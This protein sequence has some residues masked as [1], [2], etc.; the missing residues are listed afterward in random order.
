MKMDVM[1]D[2]AQCVVEGE[3][4]SMESLINK[5]LEEGKSASE[6]INSGLVAGMDVVSAL[7]KDGELFVPEVL[8]SA[9][10]MGAG[11]DLLK[12]LLKDAD[13]NSSGKVLMLTVEGDL[14]DIGKNLCSVMLESAG[15]EVI[16]IG[17]DITPQTVADAVKEHKPDLVGM[18]A[19]LTTTMEA[20]QRT[21][22][23]LNETGLSEQ[24]KLMVG[25]APLNDAYAEKIDA[26]YSADAAGIVELAKHLM[27]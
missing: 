20:M 22:D 25:G 10:A 24:V 2:I 26:F 18:S 7:F 8:M 27:A 9:Q 17:I 21:S 14:H 1:K 4:D 12:P 6:L 13:T 15:F 5:G 11:M 19:M 23:L 16:D 3:A